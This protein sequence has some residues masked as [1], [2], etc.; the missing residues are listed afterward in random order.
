MHALVES[1]GWG[2]DGKW[3]SVLISRD[4]SRA[5]VW[6]AG[7]KRTLTVEQQDHGTWRQ[8]EQ[9]VSVAWASPRSQWM[10]K[11]TQRCVAE[12][13]WVV[14]ME[15]KPLELEGISRPS[16]L[17]CCLW[18]RKPR[19]TDVRQTGQQLTNEHPQTGPQSLKTGV[20]LPQHYSLSAGR[21]YLRISKAK[22][23][24]FHHTG[25]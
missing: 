4:R 20:F 24:L 14:T 11:S 21:L 18:K 6:R 9:W 5:R 10:T 7:G 22:R 8:H 13:Q 17:T 1:Q 25:P 3:T 16:A 23:T 2:G 19:P 12:E 15:A